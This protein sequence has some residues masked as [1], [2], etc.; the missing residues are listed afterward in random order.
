MKRKKD[1]QSNVLDPGTANTTPSIN[2]L[3][4]SSSEVCFEDIPLRSIYYRFWENIENHH[5]PIKTTS[6]E[7]IGMLSPQTP[8]N[9]RRCVLGKYLYNSE[10][11]TE[12]ISYITTLK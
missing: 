6:Y 5:V 8:R 10:L 12:K 2:E 1:L 7:Q 11:L 3:Q 4:S 9:K